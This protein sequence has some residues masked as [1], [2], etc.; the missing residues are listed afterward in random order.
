VPWR[1]R[2]SVRQRLWHWGIGSGLLASEVHMRHAANFNAEWGYVAPRPGFL[3][4]ARLVVVA[5]AIGATAGAAVVFSLVDRP[6]AE[7][8]VAA[9]TLVPRP[10]AGMPVPVSVS[11]AAPLSGEWQ[12]HQSTT[13]APGATWRQ[14]AVPLPAHIGAAASSASESG[15]TSTMLRPAAGAALAEAPAMTDAPPVLAANQTVA[16]AP[17][18]VPAQRAPIKKPR[19]ASARAAPRYA[20][21]RYYYDAQR[22]GLQYAQIGMGW[23]RPFGERAY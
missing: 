18:V 11:V 4:A 1:P 16:V 12:R 10:V 23:Q 6:V 20:A 7:E 22:Y 3:R 5:G 17:A 21:S 8:S 13:D 2:F 9:R 19:L 14:A 15:T